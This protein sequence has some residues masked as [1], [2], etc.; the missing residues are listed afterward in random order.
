MSSPTIHSAKSTNMQ[1]SSKFS[2]LSLPLFMS[3]VFQSVDAAPS[4]VDTI[5]LGFSKRQ[6]VSVTFCDIQ[7]CASGACNTDLGVPGGCISAPNT[8][9]VL[10]QPGA[11]LCT[12]FNCE[13]VCTPLGD[14]DVLLEGFCVSPVTVNS[15]ML[16]Q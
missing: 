13:G 14:C 2:P 10:G 3:I 1:L 6:E 16:Q 15:I 9:C 7:N 8:G 11:L 12:G 5:E 4:V